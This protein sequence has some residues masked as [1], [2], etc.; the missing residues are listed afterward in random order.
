MHRSW[1]RLL[2][3]GRDR[4]GRRLRELHGRWRVRRGLVLTS[5]AHRP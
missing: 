5:V 3:E 1:A 2:R 4:E